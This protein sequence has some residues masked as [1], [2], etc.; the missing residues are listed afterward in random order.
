MKTRCTLALTALVL[1]GC[2]S[3]RLALRRSQIR[4]ANAATA[5]APGAPV[6]EVVREST[7]FWPTNDSRP[8]TP[9]VK[10]YPESVTAAGEFDVK[11][12]ADITRE[13]LERTLSTF[14]CEQGW[15]AVTLA[16]GPGTV[17]DGTTQLHGTFGA[18][19]PGLKAVVSAPAYH[20][21]PREPQC[22]MPVLRTSPGVRGNAEVM[23]L[24]LVA[25]LDATAAQQLLQAH[26]CA[27]GADA[28][29]I[30]SEQ[31]DRAGV[32]VN[33]INVI[34]KE[35]ATRVTATAIVYPRERV[36][37]ATMPDRI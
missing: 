1:A 33:S 16:A 2:T 18:L 4:Y 5:R 24:F 10:R 35:P 23:T 13:Q 31:Y 8:C 3:N 17:S 6:V 37:P 27:I 15:A 20:A 22:S 28:I 29:I 14:A 9:V 26:A 32:A 21:V 7:S 25:D 36:A 19:V 34:V 11:A 12:P 30:T